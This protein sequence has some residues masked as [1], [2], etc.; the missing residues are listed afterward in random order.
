MGCGL[1]MADSQLNEPWRVLLAPDSALNLE[2]SMVAVLSRLK[3][4][5]TVCRALRFGLDT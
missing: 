1:L 4:P 2:Q 3:P 5:L